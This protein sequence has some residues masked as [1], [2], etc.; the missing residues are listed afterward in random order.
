MLQSS[1]RRRE[2]Q[3]HFSDRQSAMSQTLLSSSPPSFIAA[4]PVS[5]LIWGHLSALGPIRRPDASVPEMPWARARPEASVRGATG[6]LVTRGKGLRQRE[7]EREGERSENTT[8]S[9]KNKWRRAAEDRQEVNVR[10]RESRER[11]K[12]EERGWDW[13]CAAAGGGLSPLNCWR[14]HDKSGR[15]DGCGSIRCSLLI[16]EGVAV[17]RGQPALGVVAERD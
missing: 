3:S 9:N 12:E 2:K 4:P 14:R 1:E 11:K 15:L 10:E 16:P 17:Q 6:W 13:S 8:K 5:A 7:R